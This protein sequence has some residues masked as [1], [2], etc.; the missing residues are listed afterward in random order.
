MVLKVALALAVAAVLVRVGA[1]PASADCIRADV[2][3]NRE[4]TTPT[5]L[6]GPGSCV[7]TPFPDWTDVTTGVEHTGTVPPGY[8]DGAGVDIHTVSP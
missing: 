2:Y 7:P 6:V 5:Y 3:V 4:G 8:P 1:A